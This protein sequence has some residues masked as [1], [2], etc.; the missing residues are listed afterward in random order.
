MGCTKIEAPEAEAVPGPLA[1]QVGPGKV[2]HVQ[3][4]LGPTGGDRDLR[5]GPGSEPERQAA[6]ALPLRT[7]ESDRPFDGRPGQLQVDRSSVVVGSMDAQQK[8]LVHDLPTGHVPTVIDSQECLFFLNPPQAPA[9]EAGLDAVLHPEVVVVSVDGDVRPGPE[10]T[11]MVQV[12]G[13]EVVSQNLAVKSVERVNV[14]TV[15]LCRR[16]ALASL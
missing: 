7:A 6:V 4:L 15:R 5:V 3:V 13:G 1:G 2:R 11:A 9:L 10:E 14:A 16:V 12:V 8:L